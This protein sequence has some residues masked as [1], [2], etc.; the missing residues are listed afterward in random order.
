MIWDRRAGNQ[1]L[2]EVYRENRAFA[3]AMSNAKGRLFEDMVKGGCRYYNDQGRGK[4]V[5]MPEPFRVLKKDRKNG[6]AT[7]RFTAHAQP[8]FIGCLAG[9]VCI[10][11]EAKYTDTDRLSRRVITATQAAALQTYDDM[12]AVAAVCVGIQDKFFMLPWSKFANMKKH[13]GRQFVRAADIADYEVKF[14]GVALFL[15]YKNGSKLYPPPKARY[16]PVP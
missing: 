6:L 3:A 8:D 10:A 15:D 1:K 13:Y 4:I 12:G 5:K 14:N 2:E 11:F 16:I 9:G 7:I